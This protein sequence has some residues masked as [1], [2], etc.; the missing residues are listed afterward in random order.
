MRHALEA[1]AH[2]DNAELDLPFIPVLSPN[3]GSGHQLRRSHAAA[4]ALDEIIELELDL[5]RRNGIRSV[6]II[7]PF[8][9]DEQSPLFT[10]LLTA[11][12]NAKDE[13][14]FA[15]APTQT[16][17]AWYCLHEGDSQRI[18]GSAVWPS[19]DGFRT[20][21]EAHRQE[22]AIELRELPEDEEIEEPE[23]DL[24]PIGGL[25]P[26]TRCRIRRGLP[27]WLYNR[28]AEM[29]YLILRGHEG[30]ILWDEDL[31]DNHGNRTRGWYI[32][33]DGGGEVTIPQ[34]LVGA[35][36]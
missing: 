28:Y 17:M 19:E 26:D 14:A 4:Q 18:S 20:Y 10:T 12:Q 21:C 7:N 27:E 29:G 36:L 9:R 3:N 8:K 32:Q 31:I 5:L 13:N 15:D 22:E 33:M 30:R 34:D 35:A 2:I 23:E 24:E 25:G 11:I 6:A 16:R 1:I